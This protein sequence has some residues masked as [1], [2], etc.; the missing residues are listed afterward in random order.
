MRNTKGFTLIE[1]L[2][3]IAIISILAG[4][5]LPALNRAKQ[6]AHQISCVNNLKQTG[7]A[8]ALYSTDYNGFIPYSN[9]GNTGTISARA[10]SDFIHPY[11]GPE[12]LK[13]IWIED[14]LPAYADYVD[15]SATDNATYDARYSSDG[16]TYNTAT[17]PA[18]RFIKWYYDTGGDLDPGETGSVQYEMI[19]R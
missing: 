15:A 19:I 16:I 1:L 17:S 9:W 6:A 3:V 2:V 12:A 5:L 4:M 7:I 13:E 11:L 10:W 14:A 8:F 18:A